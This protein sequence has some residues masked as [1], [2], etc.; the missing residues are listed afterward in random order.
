MRTERTRISNLQPWRLLMIFF[1]VVFLGCEKESVELEKESLDSFE[2]HALSKKHA[3]D[4]AT[5]TFSAPVYDLAAAPDG[6]IMVALNQGN[7]R[8]IQQIKNGEVSTMIEFET[9]SAVQ[10]IAPIGSGNAFVTTAGGDLATFGELYRI[11]HGNARMVADLAAFERLNDPDA[12][13]GIQ[14]KDQ[15]CEAIDG[16]SAGPQNNPFKVEAYS[17]NTA[18]IADA[19]GNTLL[20]ATTSGHV[21]W[22]AI[23]TPPVD[24][25]GEYII[26]WYAQ[27]EENEIIPC[28]VQ[29]VPTSVVIGPDEYVYVGELTGTLAVEDGLAPIGLSRVWK[30]PADANNVVCEVDSGPCQLII[31][32]LTS[33]I[34][35]AI[36]P[37]GLL[38]VVEFDE[39]S[40]WSSFYPP[41]PPAGGKISSYTL[42]GKPVDVVASGLSFPS[43]ITFDKKGNLWLLENNAIA[44]EG[45]EP[46][47]RMLDY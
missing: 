7:E 10:G 25:N 14:W 29:P 15:L 6:S 26:R 23:F 20:T 19:A 44:L 37:D 18:L 1:L 28:Y 11:S 22:K 35:L 12:Y 3:A 27:N 47:V 13:A 36:G 9:V 41:L 32:G 43:A 16:F 46:T 33:V 45:Y 42:D 17:G 30:I 8:V 5:Y 40:W 39:N 38:Y 31:N 34:D 2:E 21:D 4:D 24:D